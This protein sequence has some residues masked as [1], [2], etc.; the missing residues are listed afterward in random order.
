M[1][2]D[3]WLIVKYCVEIVR[4]PLRQRRLLNTLARPLGGKKSPPLPCSRFTLLLFLLSVPHIGTVRVSWVS[5][6]TPHVWVALLYYKISVLWITVTY[7]TSY[8][9]NFDILF[10]L[11]F[12]CWL[13]IMV[14]GNGSQTMWHVVLRFH[15]ALTEVLLR[16]PSLLG[17]K[18]H[19]ISRGG[20]LWQSIVAAVSLR[21]TGLYKC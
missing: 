10:S 1:H 18:L 9:V 17:E 8:F 21:I 15:S 2:P 13:E 20:A 12:S 14:Y 6:Q 11:L 4:H 7:W 3:F 5:V 19:T 16:L